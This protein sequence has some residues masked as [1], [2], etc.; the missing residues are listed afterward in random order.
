MSVINDDPTELNLIELNE[1]SFTVHIQSISLV[2]A[3]CP[4]IKHDEMSL[5]SGQGLLYLPHF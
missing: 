1:Y 2:L 5:P 4:C 3:L